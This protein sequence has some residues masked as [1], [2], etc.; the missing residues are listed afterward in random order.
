MA[1]RVTILSSVRIGE[2]AVVAY[3]AVVTTD[4]EPWT[5]VAG[6]P[7]KFAKRRPLLD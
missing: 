5:L 2:G 1:S 4:V 6:V 3:G 7:A